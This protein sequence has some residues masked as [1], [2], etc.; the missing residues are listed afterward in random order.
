M[1]IITGR[2]P[3]K[4]ALNADRGFDRIYVQKNAEGSINAIVVEAKKRG[5][6]IR[7]EEKQ[8]LNRLAG[9]AHQGVVAYVSDYRYFSMDDMLKAAMDR[10][11]PAMLV[12]ADGLEDPHNL[13]AV[14]RT[15]ECVGVHGVIIPKRR[16][17]GINDTVIKSSAGAAEHMMIAQTTNISRTIEELKGK[18]LWI[19]GLDMHGDNYLKAD[20]RGPVAIVVGG[21]EKGVGR[22]VKSKCDFI[23]SIPMYGKVDSLN[24]SN[25]AAVVLYEIKRQREL[26]CTMHNAQFTIGGDLWAD[27]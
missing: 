19:A 11:E 27:V 7:F 16:S 20:L 14:I 1:E 15:A 9:G 26:Q 5:I 23:V 3:V 8:I 22:L 24:A 13:G 17:A 25:A 12:I 2:N 10:N 6:D 21:E 4:E 18:G